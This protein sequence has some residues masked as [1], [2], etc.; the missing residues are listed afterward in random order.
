MRPLKK[1][2][3][4]SPGNLEGEKIHTWLLPGRHEFPAALEAAKAL[5]KKVP[6]DVL[7]YGFLADANAELGNYADAER[8]V[9]WMLDL[10]PGNLP[11]LT[12]AAYLRELFGTLMGRWN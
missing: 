8:A 11:G 10:R 5:N 1:S 12:R 7:V 3:D 4:L 2:F 9:Q 6:D